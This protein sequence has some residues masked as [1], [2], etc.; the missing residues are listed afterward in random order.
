MMS[1]SSSP[2][3]Y[4]STDH[5]HPGVPRNTVTNYVETFQR[6]I[7]SEQVSTNNQVFSACLRAFLFFFPT[8]ISESIQHTMPIASDR[9][10]LKIIGSVKLVTVFGPV[11]CLPA[12][13]PLM[14]PRYSTIV[15]KGVLNSIF[16]LL[17]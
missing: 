13:L 12:P 8:G 15:P 1:E 2:N 14:P 3:S 4:N 9:D 7:F 5:P 6:H 10:K 17:D 11:G 16:I